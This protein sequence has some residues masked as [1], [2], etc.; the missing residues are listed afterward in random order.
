MFPH[1]DIC[2]SKLI[3]SSPQLFAAYRVLLRLLMPRHSPYALLH[4]NFLYDLPIILAV[5]ALFAKLLEFLT[6]LDFVCE[7][8]LSF[9]VF[10]LSVKLYLLPFLERPIILLS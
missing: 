10:H 8:V 9:C 7:K 2:G 6:D 3:C 5:L 1:S 4:L